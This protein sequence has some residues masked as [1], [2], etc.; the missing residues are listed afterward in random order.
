V[1]ISIIFAKIIGLYCLI[2]SV[3]ALLSYQKI[4]NLVQEFINSE[5]LI[6]LAAI[7]AL[8]VGIL[9]T[10]FHPVFTYDWRLIITLFGW[11]SFLVGIIHLLIPEL[12]LQLIQAISDH[13]FLFSLFS[14]AVLACSLI[15]LNEGFGIG[16]K[17]Y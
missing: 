1:E 15:L 14:L 16:I 6:Y 12:A 17:L 10:T 3:S 13:R 11:G 2:V 4:P 5:G 9:V 7:I 8:I